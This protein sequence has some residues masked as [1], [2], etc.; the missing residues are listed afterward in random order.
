MKTKWLWSEFP[1]FEYVFIEVGAETLLSSGGQELTWAITLNLIFWDT[2]LTETGVQGLVRLASQG[3]WGFSFLH[4]PAPGSQTPWGRDTNP[5][6]YDQAAVTFFTKLHL[7]FLTCICSKASVFIAGNKEILLSDIIF[8]ATSHIQPWHFY[9]HGY[10]YLNC[11]VCVWTY[12]HCMV[13]GS[14]GKVLTSTSR[15]LCTQSFLH[16]L[17]TWVLKFQGYSTHANFACIKFWFLY[18]LLS[19]CTVEIKES[20]HL[21]FPISST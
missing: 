9:Y 4:L 6:L 3:A 21:L 13:I 5:G 18:F 17:A 20:P 12:T 16:V 15:C 8:S 11:V 19:L 2:F 14:W 10:C 7:H 1:P